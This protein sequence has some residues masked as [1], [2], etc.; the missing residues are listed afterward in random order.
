MKQSG[1]G[2]KVGDLNVNCLQYTDDAV[3][4]PSSEREL[5][6]VTNLNEMCDNNDLSLNANKT[7]VLW[8][9]KEMKKG[10]KARSV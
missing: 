5:Q 6:T 8:Y 1:I 4:I 3:I 2:V 10:R 9:L 7:K